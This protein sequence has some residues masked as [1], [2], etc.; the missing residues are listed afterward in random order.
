VAREIGGS[1]EFVARSS[2][3]RFQVANELFVEL[4]V[5]CHAPLLLVCRLG[6]GALVGNSGLRQTNWR[7]TVHLQSGS[8]DAGAAAS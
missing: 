6:G 3:D 1:D 8:L 2:H 4:I 7:S 5:G